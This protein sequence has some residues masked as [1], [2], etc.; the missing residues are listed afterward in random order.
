MAILSNFYSNEVLINNIIQKN[1]HIILFR[2]YIID[3]IH[4]LNLHGLDLIFL[5]LNQS[6]LI[7]LLNTFILFTYLTLYYEKNFF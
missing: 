3:Y 2:H 1:H 6:L 4:L 5:T 7:S